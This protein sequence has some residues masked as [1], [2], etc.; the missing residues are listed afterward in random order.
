MDQTHVR[1]SLRWYPAADT[2]TVS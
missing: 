1:T 2:T